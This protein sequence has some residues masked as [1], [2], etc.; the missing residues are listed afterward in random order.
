MKTKGLT[1]LATMA[2]EDA[3][4]LKQTARREEL[5]LLNVP[6]ERYEM[7]DEAELPSEQELLTLFEEREVAV[8]GL[9]RNAGFALELFREKGVLEE[10]RTSLIHFAIDAATARRLEEEGIPAIHPDSGGKA[11][12]LLEFMI[13]LKK[14]EKIWYPAGFEVEEEMPALFD[15][16]GVDYRR[17]PLYEKAGPGKERLEKMRHE[18]YQAKP[19]FI[20]F[21][22][23][24]AVNRL[25]AAF[26]DLDLGQ[27]VLLAL[28]RGTAE[29]LKI[30]GYEPHLTGRGKILQLFEKVKEEL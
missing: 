21:H 5:N 26:P 25:L 29:K 20:L 22:S 13:R 1:L 17:H 23:R 9:Y 7:L 18:A 4:K 30:E 15:E 24:H 6:L 14:I 19:H 11:I 8:Y 16:L 2:E 27:S 12:D 28:N 10:A 3:L